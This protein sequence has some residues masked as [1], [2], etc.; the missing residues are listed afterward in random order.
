MLNTQKVLN[1]GII[2]LGAG[3]LSVY[4]RKGDRVKFY[5]L[6]PAVLIFAK[7]HFSFLKKSK[8]EITVEIGDARISLQNEYLLNGGS[9]FDVFVLDAFSGDQIPTHLLT[10]EAFE[11]YSKHVS[12]KSGVIAVHISNRYLDLSA[13]IERHALK[14]GMMTI[15]T[16][17]QNNGS[18]FGAEWMIL[19]RDTTLFNRLKKHPNII[20]NSEVLNELPKWTDNYSN[21]ISVIK[22]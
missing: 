1:I 21:V 4:G 7:T 15:H 3:G 6:N 11:L 16:L 12:Q 10:L 20:P 19:T 9:S 17:N 2:G 13:V 22:L 14:L 18:E 5:E 8:S